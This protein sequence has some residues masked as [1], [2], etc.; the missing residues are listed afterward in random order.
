MKVTDLET[1][2]K[3]TFYVVSRNQYGTSL[4]TSIL[5]VNISSRAWAGETKFSSASPPHMLEVGGK[6]ATSLQITWNPPVIAHPEDILS[7]K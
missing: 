3:Y 6:S 7:Y 1:K 2:Y 4:P 5:K